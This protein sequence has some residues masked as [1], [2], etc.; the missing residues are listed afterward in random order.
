[1]RD[2]RILDGEHHVRQVEP[3]EALDAPRRLEMSRFVAVAFLALSIGAAATGCT[4]ENCDPN[5]QDCHEGPPQYSYTGYVGGTSSGSSQSFGDENQQCLNYCNRLSVCGAPQAQDFDTCVSDCKVRFER[6]P[7]QTAELCACIPQSRCEDA[8]EG[9]CSS[10]TSG[11]GGTG[12]TSAVPASGSPGTP[13]QQGTGDTGDT[14]GNGAAPGSGGSSPS[15]GS[16]GK[17]GGPAPGT[18]GVGGGSPEGGSPGNAAAGGTAPAATGG[19][20]TGAA[21]KASGTGGTPAAGGSSAAGTSCG[22]MSGTSG[23]PAKGEG[24]E[25]GESEPV[26]HGA[27]CTCDC[28]CPVP[29]KC[30]NGYCGG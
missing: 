18:Q 21:G 2:E 25:A 24:G 16:A 6:L 12:G 3:R 8:V 14:Y 26:H 1:M 10:G 19:S 22:A 27:A 7:Q 20:S 5:W 23:G 11:G 30:L 17:G 4:E 29:E 28:Q 15:N 9:R 13:S